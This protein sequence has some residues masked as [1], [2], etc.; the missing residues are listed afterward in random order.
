MW[1]KNEGVFI[2]KTFL[3]RRKVLISALEEKLVKGIG[4]NN[5][6]LTRRK[7]LISAPEEKLAKEIGEKKFSFY[8]VKDFRSK[9]FNKTFW[10]N[11]TFQ[12]FII[13]T[14]LVCENTDI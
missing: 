12:S 3:T 7:A 9:N 8:I 2:A 13:S 10:L 14:M 4:G 5:F 11:F 6:F 1:T